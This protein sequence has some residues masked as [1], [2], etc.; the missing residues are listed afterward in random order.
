MKS[1]IQDF[2]LSLLAVGICFLPGSFSG[3]AY[4]QND[5]FGFPLTLTRVSTGS[6]KEWE[7]YQAMVDLF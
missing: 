1:I 5:A 3:C 7:C 2:H 6:G 4:F